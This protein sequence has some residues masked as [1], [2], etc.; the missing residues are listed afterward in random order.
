MKHIKLIMGLVSIATLCGV[1]AMGQI[2]YQNGDMLAGFRDSSSPDTDLI[3]DLG[4]I[5]LFTQTGAASFNVNANLSAA[6]LGTF[7]ADLSGLSWS[8]IGYNGNNTIYNTLARS[9]PGI[10]TGVPQVGG[11]LGAQG[12]VANDID[13][14]SSL[15]TT[16]A[17]PGIANLFVNIIT[18]PVAAGGYTALMAQGISNGDF[19]GD[20]TYNI[21]NAGPGVS[22]LYQSDP[23]A[24]SFDSKLA[25]Y[26]GNFS[27][28]NSGNLTFNPVPEPATWSLIGAGMMSL[29]AVRRFRR[30]N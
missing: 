11:T 3:V 15:T 23:K 14:I 1:S 10:Q 21:E 8:V 26:L 16:G 6:L 7:G 18:V 24:N 4:S 17:W 30:S 5:S 28:D 22:D 29:L 25:T 19:A 12:L 13:T 9:N 20:W 27:L 2:N